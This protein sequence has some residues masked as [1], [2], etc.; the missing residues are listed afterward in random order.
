MGEITPAHSI[1]D[2]VSDENLATFAALE[3]SRK[4]GTLANTPE[5]DSAQAKKLVTTFTEKS[6]DE[7]GKMTK[8]ALIKYMQ[9]WH[10]HK[11]VIAEQT[12]EHKLALAERAALH[13]IP[14]RKDGTVIAQLLES[15]PEHPGSGIAYP[16]MDEDGDPRMSKGNKKRKPSQITRTDN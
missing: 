1:E 8:P 16:L 9:E 14:R 6:A 15:N 5:Q 4:A 2:G 10:E 13:G 7:L 3:E 12:L 11:D